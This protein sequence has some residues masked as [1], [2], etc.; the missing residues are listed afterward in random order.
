MLQ[1]KHELEEALTAP[2][3]PANIPMGF[4]SDVECS[5]G[6]EL[7]PGGLVRKG[8]LHTFQAPTSR[9]RVS[10]E[11]NEESILQK[12]ARE[13]REE[14]VKKAI[15]MEDSEEDGCHESSTGNPV[16]HEDI[17]PERDCLHACIRTLIY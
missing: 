9:S 12:R 15:V 10:G 16:P 3:A 11:S 17:V 5:Q 14:Q 2:P 8:A 4:S 1:T 7:K 13:K 6:S